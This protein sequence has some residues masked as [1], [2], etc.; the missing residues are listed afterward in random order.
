MIVTVNADADAR[1]VQKALVNLGVSVASEEHATDG[2]RHLVLSE[3]GPRPGADVIRKLPG[4]GSVSEPEPCHPKV[5]AHG[6]IARVGQRAVSARTPLLIGGPCAVESEAQIHRLAAKLS[7]RGVSALRG[8]AFKPRTSP[9]S[10]Q[11]H[12]REALRWLKDAS[13][14]HGLLTVTELMSESE[15]DA[16][17]ECA[18]LLQIGTRNMYNYALLKVAGA[19]GRPVLLKRAMSAT[20]REWLLAGEY[21]LSHGASSVLFCERGIRGF[22]SQTRNLL[23]LGAVALLAHGYGLPVIVDPSHAA[24]RRDLVMPLSEAA[25]AAGAAGVMIETHDAPGDAK[26]DGAQ[27]VH[28]DELQKL[29]KWFPKAV[30]G[31]GRPLSSPVASIINQGAS[32]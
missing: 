30:P 9:Y 23:D 15:V 14:E 29:A 3:A 5:S 32:S 24:G 22:D 12:G 11:G 1:S 28:P 27:A 16:V 25:L 13:K 31:K 20:V 4:V 26:S 7:A 17:A 21:L 19:T 18:D 2:K 8:G 10:F 6:P